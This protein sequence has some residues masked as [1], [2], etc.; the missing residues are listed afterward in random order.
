LSEVLDRKKRISFAVLPAVKGANKFADAYKTAYQ[1]T[2]AA[3][4]RNAE[5]TLNEKHRLFIVSGEFFADEATSPW[6][7]PAAH[8]VGSRFHGALEF[9]CSELRGSADF[10]LAQ[11]GRN[12]ITRRHL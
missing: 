4:C 3:P 11:D 9:A 2:A 8:K 5:T 12:V 10:L 6:S 7:L 1:S